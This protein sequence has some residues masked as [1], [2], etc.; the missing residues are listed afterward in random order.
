[1]KIIITGSLGHISRPLTKQLVKQ[2]H[3]VTVISSNA[4]RQE[5]IAGLGA[6]PATGSVQN[7][8]FLAATFSGADAVYCMVPA[9]FSQ[10]DQV[11]YYEK[12]GS[13][14]VEAIRRSGVKRVVHL[15][16]YGAH[17]TSGTGFIGGSYRVEQ[18][19]NAL[20]GIQLTHVRPCF[21]YYNLLSF[22]P[23]IRAAGFMGNVYGGDDIIPMVAPQD[24]AAAVAEE[25]VSTKEVRPVRYVVSDERTCREAASVLGQAIGMPDLQWKLLPAEQVEQSLVNNGVPPNAAFNLVELGLATHNGL[26]RSDFDLQQVASDGEAGSV[27]KGICSRLFFFLTGTD[28]GQFEHRAC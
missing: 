25:M 5:E 4:A 24:I 27:C 19:P 6:V 9:D 8:D 26:L 22:I 7:I 11:G 28:H 23:M 18:L 16:S 3:T 12:T 2:G 15:S 1:M 17:L 14:Y 20:P 21:F 10:P 13:C